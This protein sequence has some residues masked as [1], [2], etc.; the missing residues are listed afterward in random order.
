MVFQCYDV[1][2]T[3]TFFSV[4]SVLKQTELIFGMEASF[5]NPTLYCK[6]IHVTQKIKV[7]PSGTLSKEVDL[8]N[9]V[10]VDGLGNCCQ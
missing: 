4:H 7:L 9:F 10:T 2:C 1:K 8:E 6:E 5:H 3:A